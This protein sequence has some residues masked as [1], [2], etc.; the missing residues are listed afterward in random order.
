MIHVS[1]KPPEIVEVGLDGDGLC[2]DRRRRSQSSIV[3]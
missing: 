3:T 2:A 1:V